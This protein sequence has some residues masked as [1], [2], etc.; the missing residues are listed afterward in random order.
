MGPMDVMARNQD[1]IRRATEG[2]VVQAARRQR[3]LQDAMEG[4][5]LA[6]ARQQEAIQNAIRGPAI[7]AARQQEAL[8]KALEGPLADF[9]KNQES[10]RRVSEGPLAAINRNQDAIRRIFATLEGVD[11]FAAAEGAAD[12]LEFQE[13][14]A[15]EAEQA[16]AW[17][18]AWAEL[19]ASYRPSRKQALLLQDVIALLI[20]VMMF[21]A[22]QSELDLPP[23]LDAAGLL[24]GGGALIYHYTEE[25]E[26]EDDGRSP[27]DES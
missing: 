17:L 21:V 13:L 12:E 23:Q 1:V 5:L 4:P 20:G 24:L 11:V 22:S 9:Q 14:S 3:A 26:D 15:D 16:R 7:Q 18:V 6:M 25:D 19:L 10:I 27:G 2:P 8:R